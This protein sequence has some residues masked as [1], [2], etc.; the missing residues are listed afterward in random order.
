M[1]VLLLAQISSFNAATYFRASRTPLAS[2]NNLGSSLVVYISHLQHQGD[3]LTRWHKMQSSEAGISTAV[4]GTG[5]LP[6][7][8]QCVVKIKNH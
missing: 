1:Q 8:P 3:I 6:E 4:T 7:W 2:G 5:I